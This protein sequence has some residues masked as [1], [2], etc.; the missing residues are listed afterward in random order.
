MG[1]RRLHVVDHLT[2]TFAKE[3]RYTKGIDKGDLWFAVFWRL[4]RLYLQAP[5]LSA[6]RIEVIHRGRTI[7]DVTVTRAVWDEMDYGAEFERVGAAENAIMEQF[8]AGRFDAEERGR[9]EARAHLAFYARCL[10]RI[11]RSDKKIA[12]GLAP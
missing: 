3:R 11:P 4:E 10:A 7:A 9:R 5:D 8:I 12:K 1:S 6:V 2:D